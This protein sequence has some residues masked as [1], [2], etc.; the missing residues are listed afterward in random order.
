MKRTSPRLLTAA[1][2]LR[3]TRFAVRATTG[4]L[5]P[6]RPG[7]PDLVLVGYPGLVAPVDHGLRRPSP[8]GDR[9]VIQLQPGRDRN[10][11]ALLGPRQ[12]LLRGHAPAPQVERHRRQPEPLL[13]PPLD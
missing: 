12:R 5:A 6:G 3:V 2:R 7:A 9:R 1:I 13:Q 8:P 4:G 10:R 11:R